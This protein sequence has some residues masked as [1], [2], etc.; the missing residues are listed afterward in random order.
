MRIDTNPFMTA[1]ASRAL[2]PVLAVACA[3]SL[4]AQA[5]REE[6]IRIEWVKDL[7]RFVYEWEKENSEIVST[8]PQ[9]DLLKD[10]SFFQFLIFLKCFECSKFSNS[11][12]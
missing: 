2:A 12:N 10:F 7:K 4:W 1:V 5:D 9:R 8:Q 3:S 11:Q 6:K